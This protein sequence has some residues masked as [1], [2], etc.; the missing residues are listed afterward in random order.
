[1]TG[2]ARRRRPIVTG[3]AGIDTVRRHIG[4]RADQAWALT[5][6]RLRP[7]RADRFDGNP[8][9]ALVCVNFSTTRYLKLL[10]LTL[11]DQEHL[12]LL[13]RVVV[14]DNGSR[15]GGQ[16]FL[17]RLE[18]AVPRVHLVERRRFVHHAGGMRAGV[19]ALPRLEPPEVPRANL[20][21]FCDPDVIFRDTAT[22]GAIAGAA[23]AHSPALI[24]EVRAG[25]NPE[26]D[27]QASFFVVR[28]DV[29]ARRDI[30]PI[31]HHG[32]PAYWLQRSIRRV[33][34]P[35]VDFPSNRGGHVLHR[36]RAG[37]AAA[38]RYRTG[39]AFATVANRGPHYMGVP[40]GAAVWDAVEASHAH[41]L[42]PEAE[43]ELL[44]V[45]A[46]RLAALGTVSVED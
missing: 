17:R 26:P 43:A 21:L 46:R 3:R 36:G 8:R 30:A 13:H 19:S 25:V 39:H 31:V 7:P 38:H 2:H 29:Y 20:L 12:G 4:M 18:R 45:L 16:P 42:G 11:C 6:K 33:G 10:L 35:V 9:F 15:D 37:V 24:G 28:R 22:L 27:I 44:E 1:V 14:V 5:W 40:D 34:L 41:L 23:I 32:S